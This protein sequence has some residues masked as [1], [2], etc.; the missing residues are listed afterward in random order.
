M[1]RKATSISEG[2]ASTVQTQKRGLAGMIFSSP[3]TR[4]T[5]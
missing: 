1:A 4:A 5:A 2:M 3:V